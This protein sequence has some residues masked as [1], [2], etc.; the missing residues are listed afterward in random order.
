MAKEKTGVMRRVFEE[1]WNRGKLDVIGETHAK[2]FVW[3]GPPTQGEHRGPQA[4]RQFVAAVLDAFPDSH[5]EIEDE[6][7]SGDR[8]VIRWAEIGT[9]KKVWWGVDATGRKVT[10]SGISIVRVSGGKIAEEWVRF[11]VLDV[12]QQLDAI[13]RAPQD[14]K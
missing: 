14:R 3:H 11:D 4:Y 10:N 5:F 2:D 9:H 7:L 1:V 13:P 6:I 8:E 12:M